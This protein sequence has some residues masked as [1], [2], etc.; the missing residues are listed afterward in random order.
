MYLAVAGSALLAGV[1]YLAA[2][3]IGFGHGRSSS[4][5]FQL[6]FGLFFIGLG[7]CGLLTFRAVNRGQTRRERFRSG[8]FGMVMWVFGGCAFAVWGANRSQ[9][10]AIIF[11]L[12]VACSFP[13]V[14]AVGW[15]RLRRAET[16]P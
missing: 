14:A 8:L 10:V 3:I 1:P 11:G 4:R 6:V 13:V 2:A 15:V 9:L 16:T 5:F 7:A 12:A